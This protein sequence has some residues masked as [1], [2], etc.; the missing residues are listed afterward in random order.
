MAIFTKYIPGKIWSIIGRAGYL[1]VTSLSL[2]TTSF[3]SLK[4]QVVYIWEGLILSAIPMLLVY[5]LNVYVILVAL[6]TILI[7]LLLFIRTIH[8]W[9]VKTFKKITKK[10]LDVPFLNFSESL[11]LIQYVFYYWITWIL[12]FYLFVNSF[13]HAIGF[14]VA[15]AFSLSVTI[16][17]LAII[18]PAGLGIREGVMGSYLILSGI[19]V[20]ISTVIV[21]YARI[22]FI[23][24]EVFLFLLA[25]LLKFFTKSSNKSH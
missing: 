20:E 21:L 3:L 23:T 14:Q 16:G 15:F 11:K 1:Q 18:F 25:L 13:Y 6:L 10:N 22:W 12:A 7:T 17:L 9:F 2:K 24:G 19:P 5:G 4:E 8:E